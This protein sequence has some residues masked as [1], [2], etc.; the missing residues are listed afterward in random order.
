MKVNKN[1][2]PNTTRIYV[3]KILKQLWN[4][5]VYETMNI[6]FKEH[7]SDCLH[8]HIKGKAKQV[9]KS[10]KLQSVLCGDE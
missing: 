5:D 3:N 7:S 10:I 2:T 8:C 4:N 1:A 6:L 9:T